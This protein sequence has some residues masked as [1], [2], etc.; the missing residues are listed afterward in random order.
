M[1]R[2]EFPVSIDPQRAPPGI[3]KGGVGSRNRRRPLK[4]R[5]GALPGVAKRATFPA[6]HF[7]NIL[8]LH[9]NKDGYYLIQI[10]FSDQKY[11]TFRFLP[12]V[13]HIIIKT[14][15][16]QLSSFFWFSWPAG[17]PWISGIPTP[18]VL[19]PNKLPSLIYKNCGRNKIH[20][21]SGCDGWE[22]WDGYAVLF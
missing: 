9:G 22:S 20:Q 18:D 7:I 6:P 21:F 2:R 14:P 4:S 11:P 17:F 19:F 13:F 8:P 5:W 3:L 16:K 10:I 12:A 15:G 1:R